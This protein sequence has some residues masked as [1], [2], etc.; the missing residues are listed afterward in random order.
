[1]GVEMISSRVAARVFCASLGLLLFLAGSARAQ[2]T[3]C[4]LPSS[5]PE[6]VYFTILDSADPYFGAVSQKTCDGIVKL[7]I[8]DCKAQVKASYK[9]GVKTANSQYSIVLK[10]CAELDDPMDRDNCKGSAKDQRDFNRDGYKESMD[11]PNTGGLGMCE[12][13]FADA[14]NSACMAVVVSGGK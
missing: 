13:V 14:L 10:Q 12:G 5:V 8:A 2:Y 11:D 1:M 6:S 4:G 9:C 7:G 3:E